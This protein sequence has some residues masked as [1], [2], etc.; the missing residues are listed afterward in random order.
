MKT[1]SVFLLLALSASAQP[2]RA[3]DSPFSSGIPPNVSPNAVLAKGDPPLTESMVDVYNNLEAWLY[4][5]PRTQQ[6]RNSVRAMMIED[7]KKPAEIKGYMSNL[8]MAAQLAQAT[9]DQREFVRCQLQP[10][11]LQTARADKGNP[12]AQR[13]VAAYAQS[14]Q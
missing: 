9:P 3:G 14:H 7:W 12:D 10:G 2:G 13:I 1:L 11:N 5:L 4:E 6:Q 8:S